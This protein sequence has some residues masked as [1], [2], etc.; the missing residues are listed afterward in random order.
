MGSVVCLSGRIGSGKSSVANA[1]GEKLGWPCAGF[2]DY[3]RKELAQLGGDSNSRQALQDL[4]QSL[5]DKDAV[6]F[7]RAVI[8]DSGFVPGGNLIIDGVRHANI[9]LC[10][11][12]VVAPSTCKLIFL[13]ANEEERLRRVARR[14]LG[15]ADFAR[16]EV[17]VAEADMNDLLPTMADCVID[18]ALPLE[19]VVEKCMEEIGSWPR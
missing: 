16:A 15:E 14:P 12:E 9:Q 5:V 2:G 11:R 4:G 19:A 7:C 6:G 3:L 8:A 13:A 10:L 1:L 17:H 18:G